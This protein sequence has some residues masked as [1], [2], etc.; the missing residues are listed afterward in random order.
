MKLNLAAMTALAGSLVLTTAAVSANAAPTLDFKAALGTG[1]GL[2]ELARQGGGGGK[3]GGGAG[4]RGGGGW[5]GG[6]GKGG[7]GA[8]LAGRGGGGGAAWAG[9]G[10]GGGGP[11]GR[12]AGRSYG[13]GDGW[14]GRGGGD[15]KAGRG[16]GRHAGKSWDGGKKWDGGKHHRHGKSFRRFYGPD[17]FVYGGTGYGYNDCGWLRRQAVITGS[18]YWWQR[19]QDCLY[20]Y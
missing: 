11:S 10:G 14:K 19:Y 1:S 13:G 12:L 3:G 7:G 15:F 8:G 4:G 9:R 18:P 16:S 20:Y 2:V 5:S 6:G 17:I